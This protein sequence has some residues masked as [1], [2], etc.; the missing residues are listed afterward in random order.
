IENYSVHLDGREKGAPP[1]TLL[2]YFPEDALIL[3]DESHVTIPQV[4]GM[5]RGDQA[6]KRNLVDFGFRLPSALDNRPLSFPEFETHLHQVIYVSATPGDYELTKSGGLIAEQMIRP[7][8]LMDPVIEVRGAR[9]Q[10]DD[11]LEEIRICAKR[12]E[13]VLVTTLTKKMA[14]D[15]TDY[16]QD[17]GVR[18]RYIHSDVDTLERVELIR[19]LRRGDYDVL[20]GI[21]LLREGLDIPEVSLVGIL[22]ADKEGFLRS[23]R[24]LIQTIGR[25]SRHVNG[26]VI[27]YGDR[28]TDSMKR[29]IEETDRRRVIQHAYNQEHGITPE[30]IRK[31]IGSPLV[32]VFEADHS[33]TPSIGP[34][35]LVAAAQGTSTAE[36][37]RA[38]R[39]AAENLEFE[40]AGELRDQI[41][42]RETDA[43][44]Q[45]ATAAA[46]R[47]GR[48]RGRR[49]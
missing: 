28:V 24:S 37:R 11:I 33:T 42:A 23:T 1:S 12:D 34:G 2:S 16:L 21:N 19:G 26:R 32:E 13:R 18:V 5:F 10:V 22:D 39:E 35:G 45:D 8:G 47:A 44:T 6:R 25:A 3:I 7:T 36:L 41:R 40:R 27:L 29:A 46:G 9:Q 31:S 38:M 30:S 4:G 14:E 48:G 17:V 15:L 43:T 20:V 49:R